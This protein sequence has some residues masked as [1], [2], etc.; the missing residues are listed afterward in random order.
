MNYYVE[1]LEAKTKYK[2]INEQDTQIIHF[3]GNDNNSFSVCWQYFRENLKL[4]LAKFFRD[5]TVT[6]KAVKIIKHHKKNDKIVYKKLTVLYN[7]FH[8][9]E[10]ESEKN[11]YRKIVAATKLNHI[12][13]FLQ[14]YKNNNYKK[15]LDIGC[16][17]CFQIKSI[18]E[19][20]NIHDYYCLNIENW[21][22]ISY[23]LERKPCNLTIYD[24]FNIPYKNDEFDV[25]LLFQTLHHIEHDINI[26]MNDVRRILKKGGLLII[27]EHDC[28]EKYFSKLIDIEHG[29]YG[30][31]RDGNENF[32]DNYYG[33]YKSSDEWDKI[34]NLHKLFQI[35]LNTPTNTYYA[36][37]TK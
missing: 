16:E 37:Y 27:R 11:A 20:L 24:G 25:I 10:T 32:F 1:Y 9:K 26:Y 28:N 13:P 22:G 21:T 33:D 31:V 12:K 35:Q 19:Y 14:S 29:L 18:G 23:G 4:L 15:I 30:V 3:G 5:K 34:I 8:E 7:D 2:L 6:G 17:D 36:F